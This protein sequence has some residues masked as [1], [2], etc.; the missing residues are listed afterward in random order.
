MPVILD[1]LKAVGIVIADSQ[2]TSGTLT[3][4]TA[5]SS[6]YV[7]V[8]IRAKRVAEGVLVHWE[9]SGE[10]PVGLRQRIGS[11]R[12]E[13]VNRFILAFRTAHQVKARQ[14]QPEEGTARMSLVYE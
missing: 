12:G 5:T 11:A 13:D 7:P 1:G 3:V 10:E 9:Y 14:V 6:H 4:T 8:I 2:V